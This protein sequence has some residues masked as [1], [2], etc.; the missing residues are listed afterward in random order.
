MLRSVAFLTIVASLFVTVAPA[1]TERP[2]RIESRPSVST[3]T[4]RGVAEV[5]TAPKTFA[6]LPFAPAEVLSYTVDWN[7]YVTAAHLELTVNERGRFFGKEGL[8]LSANVRTIGLVRSLVAAVDSRSESYVDPRTL[9]PFRAERQTTR[10]NKTDNAVI[11]FDRAKG[12]AAVEGGEPVPIS[13][14]TGDTLTLFSSLPSR[15]SG[16]CASRSRAPR[17]RMAAEVLGK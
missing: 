17:C 4:P 6:K 15:S 13:A 10:N 11:T 5:E 1:Q 16:P 9:L 2:R 12:T 8:R 14:E 7:N 3:R